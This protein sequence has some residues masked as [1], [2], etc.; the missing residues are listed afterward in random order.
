LNEFPESPVAA[1][2]ETPQDSGSFFGNLLNLY[3][4]PTATFPKIF[5]RSRVWLVIL[6]QTALAVGFSVLWL[7]KVDAR[8]F[9]RRQ[10]ERNPRIQQMP[11]EQVER[12]MDAQV[13][14][15]KKWGA[16]GPAIAPTLIDLVC[17]G[18]LFFVFR[19]FLAA[20]VSFLQSLATTAWSL[21]AVGLIQ[22]P[23]MLAILSVKD[24]WNVDPNQ[25]IQA[26]PTLFVDQANVPGWLFSFL[27]S[28][29]LFTFWTVFLLATGFAVASKRSLSTGLL[30]VGIPWALWI[31]LKM[32]F[33]LMF[34]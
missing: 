13:G 30:G 5:A 4:E 18:F 33:R 31:L 19:F 7:G 16:V 32:S 11:A 3:F 21:L 14:F 27:S 26:N 34:G 17:A 6:L 22:T 12:I 24:D 28:F 9:M 29:D 10:M 8:E 1:P 20:E 23:M 2:V 25:A 15:L